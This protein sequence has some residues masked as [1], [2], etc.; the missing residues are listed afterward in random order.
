MTRQQRWEWTIGHLFGAPVSVHAA[1]FF[2]AF[3]PWGFGARA[4]TELVVGTIAVMVL[5]IAHEVGHAI[6]VRLVRLRVRR[7]RVL[8]WHGLCEY[9]TPWRREQAIAIAWGGVAAQLVVFMLAVALREGLRAAQVAVPNWLAFAI[10]MLSGYNLIVLIF[11]LLPVR[12][13]DGATAWQGIPMLFRR[14]V[15]VLRS[16]AAQRKQ[17]G[18]KA[19]HL[20]LVR[21]DE[22]EC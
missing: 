8:F 14:V 1:A 6:V 7:I 11:N 21:S 2:M 12:P 17:H 13:L 5:L 15:A 22:H 9:E 16:W 19:R 18:K 3:I 4:W 10:V 20:T